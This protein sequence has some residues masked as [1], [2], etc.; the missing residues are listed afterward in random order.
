MTCPTCRSTHLKKS[1]SGNARVR[2][3]LSLFMVW[4]RCYN[5]G[6]VFR[7]IG[8]CPGRGIPDANVEVTARRIKVAQHCADLSAQRCQQT[9]LP[10]TKQRLD[11]WQCQIGQS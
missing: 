6:R 2:F 11:R 10:P 8:L 4:V 9:V 3:P 7:R 1:K 5:C